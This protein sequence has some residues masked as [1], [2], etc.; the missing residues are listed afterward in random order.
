MVRLTA[1]VGCL[2]GTLASVPSLESARV[3]AEKLSLHPQ[4]FQTHTALA[5]AAVIGAILGAILCVVMMEASW[6][7][8]RVAFA[9]VMTPA[10]GFCVHLELMTH[11]APT[12]S[13]VPLLVGACVFGVCVACVPPLGRR[14]ALTGT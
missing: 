5:V 13:I 6:W 12:V 1:V 10:L 9:S 7:V 3:L 8:G 4:P 14:R 11:H 2:A